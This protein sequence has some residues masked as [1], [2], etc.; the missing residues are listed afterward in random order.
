MLI[1]MQ[2]RVEEE[3][4]WLQQKIE[5][6]KLEKAVLRNERAAA[7]GLLTVSLLRAKHCTPCH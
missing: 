2:K 3:R 5:E 7:E 6:F 1:A 4:K